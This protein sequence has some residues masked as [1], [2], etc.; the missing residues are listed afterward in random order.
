[1]FA[2]CA[3]R[4]TTGIPEA[5]ADGAAADSGRGSATPLHAELTRKIAAA[6]PRRN[7]ALADALAIISN[8][9]P[10]YFLPSRAR[11]FRTQVGGVNNIG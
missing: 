9:T 1:M 3:A 7:F 5:T 11:A 10:P 2:G 8:D 6:A 4:R